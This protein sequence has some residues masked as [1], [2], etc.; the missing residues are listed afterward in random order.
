[1][2]PKKLKLNSVLGPLHSL[3]LCILLS[4]VFYTMGKN[5]R[6]MVPAPLELETKEDRIQ[7]R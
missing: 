1:M 3:P 7:K 2:D 6:V 5:D 4:L